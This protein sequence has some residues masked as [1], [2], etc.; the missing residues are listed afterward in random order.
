LLEEDSKPPNY[1]ILIFQQVG[2]HLE[3]MAVRGPAGEPA[4]RAADFISEAEDEEA[5][6]GAEDRDRSGG[7]R[8]GHGPAWEEEE[9]ESAL[10]LPVS[11][12]DLRAS[13]SRSGRR[14]GSVS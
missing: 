5:G 6:G 2:S 9:Q 12:S 3:M 1:K 4:R 7:S 13:S 14:Y 8:G 10:L 11:S